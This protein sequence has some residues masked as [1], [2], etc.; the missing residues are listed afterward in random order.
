MGSHF[1]L[2]GFSGGG[3]VGVTMFFVLSGYLITTLLLDERRST[4]SSN[5]RSFYIRRAARLFPALALVLVV[6]GLGLLVAGHPDTAGSGVGFSALYVSNLAVA[7]GANLG[8][9][10]HTWS[11]SIEEQ[12]Y[13]VWPAVLLVFVGRPNSCSPVL[14]QSS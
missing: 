5:L 7:A 12:F 8:P 4:G 2:P 1:D 13:L 9:L 10:E 6:V 11:L 14:S 3:L